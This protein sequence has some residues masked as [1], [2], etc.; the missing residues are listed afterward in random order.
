MGPSVLLCL[1][2]NT[3]EV[4]EKA[5]ACVAT[6]RMVAVG[7]VIAGAHK[8]YWMATNPGVAA[9]LFELTDA[10]LAADPTI[11]FDHFDTARDGHMMNLCPPMC[12]T[13]GIYLETFTNMT[14]ITFGYI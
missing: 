1:W 9:S 5:P 13:K 4:W 8:L 3:N 11:V 2:D 14:S 10:I 12:F 6:K 7:Q